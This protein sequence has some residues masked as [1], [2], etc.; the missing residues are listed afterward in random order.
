VRIEE[1]PPISKRKTWLVIERNGQLLAA[2]EA[3]APVEGVAA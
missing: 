2:Q 1:C 3:G